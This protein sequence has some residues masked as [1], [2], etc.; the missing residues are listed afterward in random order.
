MFFKNN[1]F[2]L[3]VVFSLYFLSNFNNSLDVKSKVVEILYDCFLR[4]F[5]VVEIVLNK[6]FVKK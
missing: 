2:N 6:F 4:K 5:I 1:M 3:I